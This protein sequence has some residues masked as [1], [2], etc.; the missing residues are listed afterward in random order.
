MASSNMAA[1]L[2]RVY[3]GGCASK[4]L[5]VTA[6]ILGF[7]H[8]FK[9]A[10]IIMYRMYA[11]AFLAPLFHHIIPGHEFYP[12]PGRLIQMQETFTNLRLA[13]DSDVRKQLKE[14]MAD[15]RISECYRDL[16]QNLKDLLQFFIPTVSTQTHCMYTPACCSRHALRDC[17]FEP[18]G[19]F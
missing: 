14:A 18:S 16:L 10:H 12:Q 1:S 3:T 15:R 5:K 13:F 6:P 2:D 7:W 11:K 19:I 8:T 17:A 4:Y 9:M